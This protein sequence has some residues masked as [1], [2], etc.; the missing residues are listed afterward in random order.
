MWCSPSGW[1]IVFHCKLWPISVGCQEFVIKIPSGCCSP[2]QQY[3]YTP[4]SIILMSK[5]LSF[6]WDGSKKTRWINNKI[7]TFWIKLFR[8]VLFYIENL[9]AQTFEIFH[10]LWFVIRLLLETSTTTFILF[11]SLAINH[12]YWFTHW[13]DFP[14]VNWLSVVQKKHS[15]WDY[16]LFVIVDVLQEDSHEWRPLSLHCIR[17]LFQ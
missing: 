15:V 16:I 17:L 10:I 1:H 13:L 4:G 3:V 9:A 12:F 6:H 8:S 5:P 14:F 11:L 2:V 7:F